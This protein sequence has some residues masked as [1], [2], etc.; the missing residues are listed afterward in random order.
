MSQ[1]TWNAEEIRS[2]PLGRVL[3]GFEVPDDRTVVLRFGEGVELHLM[4]R[5]SED[6]PW[7]YARKMPDRYL[8]L[9]RKHDAG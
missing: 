4:A 7:L 3:M 5:P 1:R 2:I 8:S 9:E 6:G